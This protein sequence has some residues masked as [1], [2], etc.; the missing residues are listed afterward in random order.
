MTPD[1]G[2]NR[3]VFHSQPGAG[4]FLDML[5]PYRGLQYEVLRDVMDA[6]R[7]CAPKLSEEQ[8][9][10]ALVSAL[11]GISHLG[12]SWALEADGMLRRNQLITDSD[13]ANLAAFLEGFEYAVTMLLEGVP[14]KEAFAADGGKRE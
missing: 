6:L 14:G 12:R 7:A 5:R 3:L 11:W 4:S 8:L 10:R 13:R 2:M 1:Q 9:P